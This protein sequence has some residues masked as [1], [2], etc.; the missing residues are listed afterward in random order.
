MDFYIEA[1]FGK[2]QLKNTITPGVWISY[3]RGDKKEKKELI[4]ETRGAKAI[5]ASRRVGGRR[6]DE[7]GE[8][9]KKKKSKLIART[10]RAEAEGT[11]RRKQK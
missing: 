9:E 10:R 11:R 5:R 1:K 4:K 2:N 8:K 7:G 6:Q 3:G